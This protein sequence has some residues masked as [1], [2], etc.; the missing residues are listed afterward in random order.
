[1]SPSGFLMAL[2]RLLL[3]QLLVSVHFFGRTH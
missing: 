2:P 1:M 3:W